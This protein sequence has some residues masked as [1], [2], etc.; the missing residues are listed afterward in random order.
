MGANYGALLTA[1]SVAGIVGPLFAAHVKD[2]TGSFS[3]ALPIVATMLLMATA[4]PLDCK[5]TRLGE[6]RVQAGEDASVRARNGVTKA[7]QMQ[8]PR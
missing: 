5:K 3:G 8:P 2:I 1:W 7:S 6:D 4:L